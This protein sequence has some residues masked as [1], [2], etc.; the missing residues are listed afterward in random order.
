M[1]SIVLKAIFYIIKQG[2][3]FQERGEYY[4][5]QRRK[6]MALRRL[7]KQALQL[8]YQLTPQQG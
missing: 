8:G 5:L 7:R 2:V 6:D 3:R 4:L 1:N